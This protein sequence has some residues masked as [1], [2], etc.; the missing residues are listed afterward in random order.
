MIVSQNCTNLKEFM[1]ISTV[2]IF[3]W[4]T[5]LILQIIRLILKVYFMA[6]GFIKYTYRSFVEYDRFFKSPKNST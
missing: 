4:T 1:F 3:E 2:K 6:V 5:M